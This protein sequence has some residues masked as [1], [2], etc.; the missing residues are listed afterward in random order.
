MAG[1]SRLRVIR[2]GVAGPELKLPIAKVAPALFRFGDDFA[3]ATHADGSLITP[4]APARGGEI[5]VL[6]AIGLGQTAVDLPDR[7]I[8]QLASEIQQA[9]DFRVSLAGEPVNANRVFYVGITPKSA[10][11]YQVNVM[12][13]EAVGIDPEIRISIGNESSAAGLKLPVR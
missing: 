13:P 3:I 12:L 7:S 11:L 1:A 2:T 8:P 4:E 9:R 6:Y 5:I 10:G